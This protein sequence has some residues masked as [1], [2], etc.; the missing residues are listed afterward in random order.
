MEN[1]IELH[2]LN[3]A[4]V[5]FIESYNGSVRKEGGFSLLIVLYQQWLAAQ[6]E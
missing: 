6:H 1:V 2:R 4:N 5:D 3:E